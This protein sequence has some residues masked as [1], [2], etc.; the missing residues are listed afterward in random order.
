MDDAI[1]SGFEEAPVI[2]AVPLPPDDT[3]IRPTPDGDPAAGLEGQ[4]RADMS[5]IEAAL[6]GLVDRLLA[7][8]VVLT[9]SG[10][11]SFVVLP[12]DIWRRLWLAA[13]RPPVIDEPPFEG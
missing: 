9:R 13:P 7:G 8:P 3:A 12:L 5:A 2:M 4:P 11:D 1:P 10:R 6:P